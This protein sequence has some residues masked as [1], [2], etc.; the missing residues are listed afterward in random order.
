[1]RKNVIAALA[2]SVLLLSAFASCSTK[3]LDSIKEDITDQKQEAL[4]GEQDG[5][6]PSTKKPT[7]TSFAWVSPMTSTNNPAVS[8]LLEAKP[9]SVSDAGWATITD[10]YL[11]ESSAIPAV[12]DAA[13]TSVKPSGYTFSCVNGTRTLYARARDS[14]GNVSSPSVLS[15]KL[16][17]L[18]IVWNGSLSSGQEIAAHESISFTAG[19]PLSAS[20]LS[21]TGTL[22]VGLAI[23]SGTGNSI[24]TVSPGA[25][26]TGLWQTGT[27]TITAHCVTSYG[28]PLD[29]TI[30]V[31][32]FNGVCVS[33]TGSDGNEGGSHSPK[34]TI[35]SAI[36]KAVDKYGTFPSTVRVAKGSYSIDSSDASQQIK[37]AA[38]VTVTGEYS[39]DFQTFAPGASTQFRTTV[40]KDAR[41]TDGTS[42]EDATTATILLYSLSGSAGVSYL[43]IEGAVARY[44]PVIQCYNSPMVIDHCDIVTGSGNYERYAIRVYGSSNPTI[45]NNT[46]NYDPATSSVVGGSATT[47]LAGAVRLYSYTG[48][49]G[50]ISNNVISGGNVKPGTGTTAASTVCSGTGVVKIFRNKIIAG[51][52]YATYALQTLLTSSVTV[53]FYNNLLLCGNGTLGYGLSLSTNASWNQHLNI[54]NNTLVLG[55]PTIS[56]AAEFCINLVGFDTNDTLNIQNNLFYASGGNNY[57]C[58]IYESLPVIITTC[59]NNAFIKFNDT[60]STGITLWGRDN[61][62]DYTTGFTNYDSVSSLETFLGA[63]KASGNI[64]SSESSINITTDYSYIAI[65]SSGLDGTALSWG[66]SDDYAGLSRTGNGSIGW[67][68]GYLEK[69]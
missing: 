51:T 56:T 68:V 11:S 63:A 25:S 29:A 39:A 57:I 59:Q 47:D 27:G 40:I 44:C 9:N 18:P 48:T 17:P 19:E 22:G 31:K 42:G 45:T 33:T 66:F 21:V 46:I 32:P 35:S 10:W 43:K 14:L 37:L 1:M 16:S 34:K 38:G 58:A 30:A 64:I 13:W 62:S 53:D 20:G 5:N 61:D 55:K 23:A 54:R 26:G 15:V 3:L 69:N 8:F 36:T 24:V 2:V 52:G 28:L 12:D 7:I 49:S 4:L 65:N 41:A 50:V 6:T 67:S 60:G